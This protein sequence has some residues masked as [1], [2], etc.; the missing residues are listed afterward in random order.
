MKNLII[1][2]LTIFIISCNKTKDNYYYLDHSVWFKY[3]LNDT[4]KYISSNDIDQ[5]IIRNLYTDYYV[6]DKKNYNEYFCVQYSCISDSVNPPIYGFS[7]YRNEIDINTKYS[8]EGTS[9]ENGDKFNYQLGDSTIND[10]YKINCIRVDSIE[11]QVKTYYYS[12]IYGIVRYDLYNDE[13]FELQ[14]K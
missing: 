8:I 11:H 10:V 14:L 5:Y 6:F 4:L 7:R 2:L 12:D 9:Y 1:L 13:V 3:K